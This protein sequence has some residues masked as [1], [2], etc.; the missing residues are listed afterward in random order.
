MPNEISERQREALIDAIHN[1]EQAL[2]KIAS[3]LIR[4]S[5][6]DDLPELV[7]EVEQEATSFLKRVRVDQ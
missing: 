4:A 7:A 3:K 1:H 5:R 6:A 2:N